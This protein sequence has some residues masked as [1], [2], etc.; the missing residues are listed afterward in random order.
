MI[1]MKAFLGCT[2]LT[3]V[4]FAKATKLIAIDDMAFESCNSLPDVK[5]PKS[6]KRVGDDALTKKDYSEDDANGDHFED[7]WLG[8]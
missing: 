7:Y 1:G 8:N 5:I 4:N 6:V 2:G 3:D